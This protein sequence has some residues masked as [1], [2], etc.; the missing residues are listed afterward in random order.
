[1]NNVFSYKL[2]LKY[3]LKSFS[4]LAILY[5]YIYLELNINFTNIIVTNLSIIFLIY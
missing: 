3:L 5:L 2:C 1:M 4:L